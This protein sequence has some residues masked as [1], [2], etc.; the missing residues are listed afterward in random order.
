MNCA[1]RRRV[2]SDRADWCVGTGRG[3]LPATGGVWQADGL[4]IER[5]AVNLSARQF[6]DGNLS[7]AVIHALDNSGVDPGRLELELT[8]SILM[9]DV[10]HSLGQLQ[11]LKAMGVRLAIDDF[12]TGYSFAE[13]PETIP[14]RLP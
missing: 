11:D 2:G 5:M 14:A 4:V 3:F 6:S 1:D 10:G 9:D 12:G 13:L 7:G 8:E